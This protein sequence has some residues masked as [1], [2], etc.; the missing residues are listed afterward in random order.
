MKK[1]LFIRGRC[2][3]TEALLTLDGITACMVV[4]GS[5]TKEMFLEYLEFI[6]VCF[7]CL[8]LANYS[9]IH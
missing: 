8:I 6:V 1:Q 2:T 3:S 9:Q 7:L 4:E 5:M